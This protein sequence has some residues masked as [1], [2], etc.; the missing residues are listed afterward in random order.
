MGAQSLYKVT[1]IVLLI[2]LFLGT[3]RIVATLWGR[4]RVMLQ[5]LISLGVL[6]WMLNLLPN[7]SEGIYWYSGSVSYL[8]GLIPLM[9][10]VAALIRAKSAKKEPRKSMIWIAFLVVLIVGMNEV[11]MLAT[12]ILLF[13]AGVRFKIKGRTFLLTVAVL[14]GAVVYFAPGNEIRAAHF[15]ENHRFFYSLGMT[16]LQIVRFGV[17][18]V[19][20][21]VTLLGTV[22]WVYLLK[23][24]KGKYSWITSKSQFGVI[25]SVV[26]L[27][28]VIFI[29]VFPPYWATGILGQHRTV[30]LSLFLFIPLWLYFV[31]NLYERYLKDLNGVK[32][33]QQLVEQNSRLYIV[34]IFV[35]I[36][37]T[38]N[39]KDAYQDLFS[40]DA[41]T[42]DRQMKQRYQQIVTSKAEIKLEPISVHPKTLFVQDL[43]LNHKHWVNK[44]YAQYFGFPDKPVIRIVD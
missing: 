9:L 26:C 27:V 35:T 28:L 5:L 42:F 15:S 1:P 19:F 38:G 25:H 8:F 10:L 4:E 31:V 29:G 18:W 41:F 34:L 44:G 32:A 39:T 24:W 33:I 22:G 30:N 21:P 11:L 37:C 43:S 36:L 40:G 14:A 20:S 3:W 12:L 6:S 16:V 23:H 13:I 17:K 7:L 2:G